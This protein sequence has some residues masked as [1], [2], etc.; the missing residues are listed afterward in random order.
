MKTVKLIKRFIP[1]YKPYVGIMVIDLFC[2]ALTTI[3]EIVLP[4]IMRNITNTGVDNFA[5]L[6]V[7]YVLKIGGLYIVLRLI[8]AAAFYYMSYAGH[9][10]GTKMETAMR[11]DAYEHLQKLSNT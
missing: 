8:D 6:T 1:Y 4:L 2:A 7:E 9:V 5:A 10:M 3:C 11:H